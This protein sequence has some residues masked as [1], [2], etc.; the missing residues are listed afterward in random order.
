MKEIKM[1]QTNEKIHKAVGLGESVF[2][3][4]LYYPR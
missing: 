1:T 3:K 2:S 4:W